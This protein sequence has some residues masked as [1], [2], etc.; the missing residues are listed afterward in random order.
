MT[1]QPTRINLQDYSKAAGVIQR[2]FDE[3]SKLLLDVVA[4]MVIAARKVSLNTDTSLGVDGK[5]R[6]YVKGGGNSTM[7]VSP[8][9][10]FREDPTPML[11][12]EYS[13]TGSDPWT[14]KN[15]WF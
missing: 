15:T 4:P 12:L 1:W 6:L 9:W 8:H 3:M 13:P 7:K 14:I 2:N 11:Y 10:R 5:G